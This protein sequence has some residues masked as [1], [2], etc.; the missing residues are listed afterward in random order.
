M[1]GDGFGPMSVLSPC[2]DFAAEN[3]D[4]EVLAE[5]ECFGD[6][7]IVDIIAD[8]ASASPVVYELFDAETDELL[9][10]QEDNI[11]FSNIG[12]GEYY[13]AIVDDNTCRDTTD[14][15]AFVNPPEL[16]ANWTLVQDNI[17]PGV[18]DKSRMKWTN[19][20]VC[21][22]QMEM[23]IGCFRLRISMVA[24]WIPTLR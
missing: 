22:A 6:L 9:A 19:G 3:S 7:A 13:V 16:N 20:L 1:E 23:A 18:L 5:I 15:F 24:C 10:T 4:V 11:T 17:C 2:A 12:A 21:P 14:L 8:G